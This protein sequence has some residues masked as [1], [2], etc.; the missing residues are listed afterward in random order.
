[1][2]DYAAGFIRW[3]ASDKLSLMLVGERWSG[4]KDRR[5]NCSQNYASYGLN[6]S[7]DFFKQI[8]VFN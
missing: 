2:D 8:A 6:N 1:M 5:R 4:L 7:S 3:A